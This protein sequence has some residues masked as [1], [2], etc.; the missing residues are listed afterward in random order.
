M[1]D[2]SIKISVLSL[3]IASA[4]LSSNNVILLCLCIESG[5]SCDAESNTD[6][7]TDTNEESIA[8]NKGNVST[9]NAPKASS[10]V[11]MHST[12]LDFTPKQSNQLSL[13]DAS[14]ATRKML[15]SGSKGSS[16][17]SQLGMN[18]YFQSSTELDA[19]WLDCEIELNQEKLSLE[20]KNGER[21]K[22]RW[23]GKQEVE[24]RWK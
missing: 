16:S 8:T 9:K 1:S 12:E 19:R 4:L 11:N 21:R 13:V 17:H 5:V 23:T 15:R 20:K 18:E 10:E 2:D 7:G 14:A 22:E 6:T 3:C 24:G